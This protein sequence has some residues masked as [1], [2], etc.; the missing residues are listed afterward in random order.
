[1]NRWREGMERRRG[2]EGEGME[3]REGRER[4]V[5]LVSQEYKRIIK[6]RKKILTNNKCMRTLVSGD[7]TTRNSVKVKTQNARLIL[8]RLRMLVIG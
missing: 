6:K 8:L 2:S 3:G 4:R 5:G 7:N 1:M